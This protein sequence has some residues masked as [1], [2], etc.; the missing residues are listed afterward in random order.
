VLRK[1]LFMTTAVIFLMGVAHIALTAATYGAF[2]L[3]AMWFAGSG[4]ALILLSLLIYVLIAGEMKKPLYF[5]GHFANLLGVTLVGLILS[6][7][8]A[9]H[10]LALLIL[11][12]LQ[13]VIF[14]FY[15]L[16]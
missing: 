8:F 5:V 7:V 16:N 13:T 9:P 10:I 3:D 2:T 11:L 1:L 4:V 6:I 12:L 14:L 15:H